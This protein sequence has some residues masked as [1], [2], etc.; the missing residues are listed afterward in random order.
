MVGMVKM[1]DVRDIIFHHELYDKLKISELMYMPHDFI[2]PNDSMEVVANKFESSGR[3]NIAVIEN[4][5]YLGIYFTGKGFYKLPKTDYRC[6]A[7]LKYYGCAIIKVASTNWLPGELPKF[8][9]DNSYI[10]LV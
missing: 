2:Q 1:D 8:P 7:R 4:G 6:F 5:K 3:Y 10:F 9:K